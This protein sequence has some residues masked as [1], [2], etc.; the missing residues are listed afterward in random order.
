MNIQTFVWKKLKKIK[1]KKKAQN[2]QIRGRGFNAA[3]AKCEAGIQ[4]VI[5]NHFSASA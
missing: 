1:K 5:C 2:N 4:I 3:P